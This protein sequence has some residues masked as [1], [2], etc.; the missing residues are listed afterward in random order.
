MSCTSPLAGFLTGNLTESGKREIIVTREFSEVM[1]FFEAEKR[2]FHPS[3]AVA[4]V[5]NGVPFL[6]D[7]LYLPCGHCLACRKDR[8]SVWASRLQ[9]ESDMSGSV[10]FVTLTYEDS[11]LP[12]DEF[13]KPVLVKS[14]L[15]KFFKRLRSYGCFFRYF[16]CG[17]YG[18]KR[19]RPHFHAI[20]FFK[21]VF[22]LDLLRSFVVK[23]WSFGRTQTVSSSPACLSY[24]AGYVQKKIGD[25]DS[26]S[27]PPFVLMSR[28]PGIGFSWI[29]GREEVVKSGFIPL[30]SGKI[31]PVPRSFRSKVDCPDLF[32]ESRKRA[33][34]SFSRRRVV[35]TGSNVFDVLN[36]Q[37]EYTN[38]VLSDELDKRK[39]G[40]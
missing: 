18:N 27:V 17:E 14:D 32:D 35:Y 15:Q 20:I 24:V 19:G 9:C 11:F 4:N 33:K 1:P 40:F 30:S 2:G 6:V 38:N 8:A 23:A 26:Y 16:A 39:V 21:E 5:V 7:P 36:N 28:K 13:S 29:E 34:E 37:R 10:F 25:V 22:P 3:L 31:V 12:L